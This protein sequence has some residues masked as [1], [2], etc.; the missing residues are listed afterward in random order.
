MRG[1]VAKLLRRNAE[2]LTVGQYAV[3]YGLHKVSHSI[4][5]QAG[6]TRSMY[7]KMKATYKRVRSR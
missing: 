2:K 5:L 3:L 1:K 4:W 7:Q 6:C